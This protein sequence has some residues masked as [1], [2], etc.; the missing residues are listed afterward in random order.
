MRRNQHDTWRLFCEEHRETLS[1]T[2][3]PMSVTHSEHRFRDLLERGHVVAS[4]A[5]AS[6]GNL[7]PTAWIA[8]YQF[9][10]VFFRGF[11]SYAPEDLF[12]AF[13]CEVQ[14]RGEEFPR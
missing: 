7:S 9:A 13:R 12:P 2:E 1:R 10:T 3:L 6:L 14:R 5:Q 8:L 11:E 4:D